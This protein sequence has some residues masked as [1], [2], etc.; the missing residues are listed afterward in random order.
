MRIEQRVSLVDIPPTVLH[1]VDAGQQLSGN[2]AEFTGSILTP[3]LVGN[4]MEPRPI[5]FDSPLYFDRNLKG[6]IYGDLLYIGGNDAVL[7][8][9]LY[10]LSEDPDAYFDIIRDRP[11]DA[12]FLSE[13]LLEHADLCGEIADRID[14]GSGAA[15]TELFRSLGYIN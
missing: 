14:A 13:L 9:R 8:P 10:D 1:L 15:D 12:A 3:L 5:F 7:R 6:V 2:D 11:E 4:Q